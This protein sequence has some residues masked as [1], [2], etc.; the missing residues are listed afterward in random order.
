VKDEGEDCAAGLGEIE[1]VLEGAPG[2][3][4]VAERV[5][6]DRLQQESLNHPAAAC[7]RAGLSWASRSA[8]TATRISPPR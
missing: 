4:R 2:G 5:A 8:A 6:R 3:G 7:Y 1:R